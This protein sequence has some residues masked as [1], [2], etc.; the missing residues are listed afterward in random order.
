MKMKHYFSFVLM[1][2]CVVAADLQANAP[3]SELLGTWKYTVSDV[4]PEYEKGLMTFEQKDEKWVGYIGQ[5][6]KMEMK[7]LKVE[8]EK[9]TFK[10][11]LEGD[12]ISVNL[13]KNGDKLTGKVVSS[14]GEFSIVA[15]KEVKK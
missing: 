11:N 3:A 4:P 13:T 10:I 6:E 1:L 5:A 8:K 9:I 15:A 2:L 12:L 14:E 7:E